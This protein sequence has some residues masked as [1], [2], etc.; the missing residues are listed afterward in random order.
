MDAQQ[1][2]DHLYQLLP[3]RGSGSIMGEWAR[4]IQ[5][6][7]DAE[8]GHEMLSCGQHTV[9]ADKVAYTRPVQVLYTKPVKML[10]SHLAEELLQVDERQEGESHF[11]LRL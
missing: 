2:T 11:P 8:E 9:N 7:K 6:P 5:E 4:R 10:P 3:T 1:S